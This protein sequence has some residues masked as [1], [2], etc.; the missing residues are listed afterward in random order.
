MARFI[1]VKWPEALLFQSIV[2]WGGLLGIVA[3]WLYRR[4]IHDTHVSTYLPDLAQNGPLRLVGYLDREHEFAKGETS[5]AV[6]DRL[7]SL[8]MLP[9]MVTAGSHSCNLG[10]CGTSRQEAEDYWRGMRIP[11]YCSTE[12]LVPDGT[13]LYRA[14]ALILHYIRTHH[15]LPPACFLDAVLN[16][17]E[18]GS[19]EYRVAIKRIAPEFVSFVCN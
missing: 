17:P 18:P 9:V 12:I 13:V 15:Y 10:L 3:W 19:D 14:P 4:R 1:N 8:A 6:F 11:Q 2:F 16:C 7:V 5:D